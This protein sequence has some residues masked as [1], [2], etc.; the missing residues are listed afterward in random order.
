[1]DVMF[2]SLTIENVSAYVGTRLAFSF[3]N[4]HGTHGLD[5]SEEGELVFG[6]W[7]LLLKILKFKGMFVQFLTFLRKDK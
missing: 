5:I 7:P 4:Y 6:V 2:M 1:M 3:I